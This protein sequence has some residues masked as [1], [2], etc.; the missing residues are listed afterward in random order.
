MSSLRASS[1]VGTSKTKGISDL[2]FQ[3]DGSIKT[4]RVRK[5]MRN[6]S[7]D[8]STRET[9]KRRSISCGY[10]CGLLIGLGVLILDSRASPEQDAPKLSHT[11]AMKHIISYK[12]NQQKT[13]TRIVKC[14]P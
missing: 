5:C 2:S 12:R 7:K 4:M 9:H 6:K 10:Y 13:Q 1:V 8:V 3:L 11:D 14:T